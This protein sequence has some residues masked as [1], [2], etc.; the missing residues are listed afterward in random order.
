MPAETP[1]QMV[2]RVKAMADADTDDTWDLSPNDRAALT[3]V[4]SRMTDAE[5]TCNRLMLCEAALRRVV[6]ETIKRCIDCDAPAAWIEA[7]DGGGRDKPW[8]DEHVCIPQKA[9][10]KG[11]QRYQPQRIRYAEW[12]EK[13]ISAL[14]NVAPSSGKAEGT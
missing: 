9:I 1:V 4:L 2:D 14:S 11:A 12:L 8:C 6:D 10:S 7:V 3:H 13:A 5:S